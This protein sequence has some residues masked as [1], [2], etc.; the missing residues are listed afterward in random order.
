M[1]KFVG[2]F[3][4]EINCLS[5][6]IKFIREQY[7][8]QNFSSILPS[9]DKNPPGFH[10]DTRSQLVLANLIFWTLGFKEGLYIFPSALPSWWPFHGKIKLHILRK[11]HTS[12]PLVVVSLFEEDCPLCFRFKQSTL[13]SKQPSS[14]ESRCHRRRW[15]QNKSA[16]VSTI[17]LLYFIETLLSFHLRPHLFSYILTISE[18][19]YTRCLRIPDKM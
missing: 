13:R 7:A 2:F 15:Q 8:R 5:I 12:A 4:L 6:L 18:E 11:I 17:D 16:T 19:R 10:K 14:F 1:F 9:R 3:E